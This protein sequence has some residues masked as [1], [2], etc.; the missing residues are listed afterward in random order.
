MEVRWFQEVVTSPRMQVAS[1]SWKRKKGKK[2][3]LKASRI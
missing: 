3:F 1:R 2:F